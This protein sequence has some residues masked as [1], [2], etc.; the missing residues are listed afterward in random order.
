[1]L[2]IQIICFGPLPELLGWRS[3]SVES[4]SPTTPESIA[5]KLG[6]QNWIQHGLTYHVDGV[7]VAPNHSISSNVELALLPPVSGG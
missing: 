2:H 6:L 4:E 7:M 5:L 1:M 3:K